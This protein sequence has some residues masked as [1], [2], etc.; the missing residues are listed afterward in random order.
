MKYQNVKILF[1]FQAYV[2]VTWVMEMAATWVASIKNVASDIYVY[3]LQLV[4][5]IVNKIII[6]P[7]YRPY[8]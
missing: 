7:T 1:I 2:L 5:L 4:H 8:I 6:L 3:T